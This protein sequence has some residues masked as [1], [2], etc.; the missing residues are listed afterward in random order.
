MLIPRPLVTYSVLAAFIL[1]GHLSPTSANP[2]PKLVG[3]PVSGCKTTTPS[4]VLPVEKARAQAK[5]SRKPLLLVSLNGNLDG[6]C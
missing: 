4:W 2:E 5:R 3:E 6:Y 1:L